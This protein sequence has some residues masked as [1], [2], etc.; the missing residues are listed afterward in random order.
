LCFTRYCFDYVA[1]SGEFKFKNNEIKSPDTYLGA[2]V[3]LKFIEGMTCWKMSS[4]KYVNAAITSVQ[5]KLA[6]YNTFFPTKC[7]TPLRV[8][9]RPEDDV[10]PVLNQD[11]ITYHQELVGMLR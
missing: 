4:A 6:A 8:G 2:T 7:Y 1:D 5:E 3:K 10:S 9:Y 11:D